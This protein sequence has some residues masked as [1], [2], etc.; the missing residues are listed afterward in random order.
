MPATGFCHR[1]VSA[2]CL[3]SPG[4]TQTGF[5]V[6]AGRSL[7]WRNEYQFSSYIATTYTRYTGNGEHEPAYSNRGS[8]LP[9]ASSEICQRCQPAQPS[10]HASA[11]WLERRLFAPLAIVC[12]A[13][14]KDTLEVTLPYASRFSRRE[15][16]S[17]ASRCQVLLACQRGSSVDYLYGEFWA[18]GCTTWSCTLS[19]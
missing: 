6:H 3:Q 19:H 1:S 15:T 11:Y 8:I 18:T 14:R 9:G 7:S 16:R 13:Y 10:L 5:I 12:L 17:C 4:S 2:N